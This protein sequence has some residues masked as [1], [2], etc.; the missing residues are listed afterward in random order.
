MRTFILSF[1]LVFC[2]VFVAFAQKNP[3]VVSPSLNSPFS[4]F[5]DKRVGDSTT[6]ENTKAALELL[7]ERCDNQLMDSDMMIIVY[8][9]SVALKR[10]EDDLKKDDADIKPIEEAIKKLIKGSKGDPVLFRSP[11][12]PLQMRVEH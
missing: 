12:G 7:R 11:A 4:D 6:R 9:D 8:G 2:G 5:R 1:L 10:A 3:I